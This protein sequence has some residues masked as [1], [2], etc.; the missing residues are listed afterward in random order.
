MRGHLE[1]RATVQLLTEAVD[2]M[3]H[4]MDS[5]RLQRSVMNPF[6]LHCLVASLAGSIHLGTLSDSASVRPFGGVRI[7]SS[8]REGA[9][10][11][12]VDTGDGGEERSPESVIWPHSCK[13][14]LS[15]LVRS[16]LSGLT[17][18]NVK[19]G[20]GRRALSCHQNS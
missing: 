4:S 3:G 1:F 7:L 12:L 8:L 20:I 15:L 18:T 16:L 19:A 6:T 11:F 2:L 13:A 5:L 10:C 17:G 9:E 14:A